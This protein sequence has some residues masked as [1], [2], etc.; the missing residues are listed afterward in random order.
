MVWRVM[1]RLRC[2][3]LLNI[4]Y[5]I[6]VYAVTFVLLLPVIL[7]DLPYSPY[8]NGTWN[9]MDVIRRVVS[10]CLLFLIYYIFFY[11]IYVSCHV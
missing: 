9:D 5:V 4:V 1:Q 7:Q 2:A 6:I 8:Y 3:Q 10:V 11:I